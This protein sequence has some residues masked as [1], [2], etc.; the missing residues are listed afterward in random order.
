MGRSDGTPASS[1]CFTFASTDAVAQSQFVTRVCLE[2]VDSPF[3]KFEAR[4]EVYIRT[5][6]LCFLFL[7]QQAKGRGALFGS[8]RLTRGLKKGARCQIVKKKGAWFQFQKVNTGNYTSVSK[9]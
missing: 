2:A 1:A 6:G 5:R 3:R 7:F 4:A 8:A 9:S